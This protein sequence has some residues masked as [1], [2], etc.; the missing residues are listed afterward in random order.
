MDDAAAYVAASF[1]EEQTMRSPDVIIIGGG[2]AGLA[3]SRSLTLRQVDHIVLEQRR[4][5]ERWL[6]ECWASLRLLTPKAMSV[7]PGLAHAGDAETFLPAT[8]FAAYLQHYVDAM[9]LP[10]ICGVRVTKVEATAFGYRVVSNA[11]AWHTK[12][13]VIAT[14]ACQIPYRPAFAGALA[15][16]I[17]QIAPRDYRTPNDLPAGGVLVVGASATGVQLA[18][19]LQTS[20]RDVTLAVG[21]HTRLPRRYRGRDIF[22]WLKAAGILDDP[23][24]RPFG[25]GRVLPSTQ[26][27]GS[28]DHRDLNL[29]SLK[30][31]GVRIVGRLAGLSGASAT[32]GGDLAQSTT[33]AH[34]RLLRTLDRIDSWI[35]ANRVS[36]PDDDADS[37]ANFALASKSETIDLQRAG[38]RTIV[39]ATGYRRAYPW[40]HVPVINEQGDIRHSGG[41]TAAPG[42]FV[43]GLNFLRRRRSHFID[44]CGTDADELA[45]D[46]RHHLDSAA[47]QVA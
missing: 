18:E 45:D 44:G 6:S 14:G 10:V 27:V 34:L 5:G 23:Q 33:A 29:G 31:H 26:L 25:H 46:V 19:E 41:L 3:M 22:A 13:V 40:L 36:A 24:D 35:D 12:C 21:A 9:Q 42:L 39:W 32:F 16:S 38:I 17:V 30:R 15:P 8:A 11:G 20:G 28:T 43:I 37:R 2:Q 1:A 7:L 47:R 4:I